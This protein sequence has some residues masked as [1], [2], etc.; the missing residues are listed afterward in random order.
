[1]MTVTKRVR[2]FTP[3]LLLIGWVVSIFDIGPAFSQQREQEVTYEA[4]FYYTVEKGDTLWDISQR[5]NDTPWQWPD[6]W[7]KN[8]QITNPHWIYP[9][10]RIRL[11]RKSDKQKY[12]VAEKPEPAI[13]PRIETQPETQKPKPDVHLLFAD[14]DKV[15]FIR[16]PA[17]RPD[18]QI[19]KVLEDKE[20]I[21]VDDIVYIN[22]PET[23]DLTALT[24]GSRWTVYRTMAPK[25]NRDAEETIGTQHYFLGVLEVT[26]NES[27][28]AIAKVI[29]S[30]HAMKVGDLI[31]PYK[32]RSSE[33]LV[34]DST[35]GIRG[36]IIASEDHTKLIGENVIAF[37]DKG[38]EDNIFP[39][40]IYSISY[41]ETAP[42]G[43]GGQP[44]D[45]LP[46]DVGSFV[47]LHTEK[48]TSTVY[49]IDA[50]RK[51][52]PGQMIRTP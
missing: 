38:K 43:A 41:Q 12:Q 52:T 31:M 40:Q 37:I 39:G 42:V 1:M 21:S 32:P 23:G 9:G 30:Y 22:H 27:Q 47:V 36:E 16:K 8:D 26:Q 18:G 14:I 29:N 10:E 46:V 4:G 15:G 3:I 33:F 19:F 35:P 11:Y 45:L 28:Y 13:E 17:V 44:I 48:T 51:I 49:V 7:Q 50:S 2:K 20:L 6:L 5:F 34:K 25:D 24:A